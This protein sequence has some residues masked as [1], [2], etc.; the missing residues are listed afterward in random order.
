M[1]VMHRMSH[2]EKRA[3]E[4]LRNEGKISIG[5]SSIVAS[6][7]GEET[8][9]KAQSGNRHDFFEYC[10]DF[11]N[12][13]L[14]RTR[15]YYLYNF[16]TLSEGDIVLIPAPHEYTICKVKKGAEVYS[17]PGVDIG[18]VVDVEILKDRCSRKDSLD[19][20]LTQKMK[21][22]GTNLVLSR[23][24]TY[25][26][27]DN[28]LSGDELGN[29]VIIQDFSPTKKVIIDQIQTYLYDKIQPD[30]LERIVEKYL[31]HI[32]AEY[33]YIPSKNSKHKDNDSCADIDVIGIFPKIGVQ[34][35]V[36]VKQHIG[37]T[38]SYGIEQLAAYKNLVKTDENNRCPQPVKCF[39]TLGNLTVEA[40]ES[41][42]KE[43]IK[44]YDGTSFAEELY[45]SGFDFGSVF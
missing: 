11:H 10:L 2:E 43:S 44:V 33:A 36:Q 13:W 41:A 9:Q 12:E 3:F 27:V 1:Y 26:E 21:F 42:E 40:M 20:A 7:S 45:D 8:I 28:L 17:E 35:L 34:V 5:W 37:E 39:I 23:E 22:R 4:L 24:E 29:T 16:L 25:L 18:F 31:V 38:D 15:C 14:T 30:D 19:N 6:G 32:G